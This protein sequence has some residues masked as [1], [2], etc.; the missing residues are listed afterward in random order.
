L[1][2]LRQRPV[3]TGLEVWRTPS[4]ETLWRDSGANER[5]S[6]IAWT[7]SSFVFVCW[8]K[9][10]SPL[11]IHYS[12][13]VVSSVV[14]SALHENLGACSNLYAQTQRYQWNILYVATKRVYQDIH[15]IL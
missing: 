6:R 9:A 3:G 14:I 13:Q 1:R 8:N 5:F 10:Q 11:V 12:T 2:K 15:E 4:R 7:E